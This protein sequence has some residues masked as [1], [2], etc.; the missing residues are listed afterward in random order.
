MNIL[1]FNKIT[2][3]IYEGGI[4]IDCRPQGKWLVEVKRPDGTIRK[5]FGDLWFSNLFTNSFANGYLSNLAGYM[6]LGYMFYFNNANFS[7]QFNIQVGSS[8]TPASNSDTQLGNL[9]KST[10]TKFT[11]G[12]SITQSPTSGNIVYTGKYEFTTE[13]GSVTYNEAGYRLTSRGLFEVFGLP[14][15]STIL[16]NRVVFPGAVN[17]V[18]G[19]QLILS[20]A[21][22]VPTLAVTGRTITIAAQNGMN[23]SGELR[24]IGTTTAMAGGT[25]TAAGVHTTNV[26]YPLIFNGSQA[27]AAGLTTATSFPGFNTN[28]SGLGTNS[29]N[30]TWTA[31]T[32]N[33]RNR[34]VSFTWGSGT[35]STDTNF[36]SITFRSTSGNTTNGYQLLL[37]NQMTKAS[38]AT[39]A[40]SLRF[41]V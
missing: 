16:I 35:P 38:A 39:L 25:V 33:S 30:G 36:R 1:S 37:D 28:G 24:C 27:P 6:T 5:P 21:I 11:S 17:L 10:T 29:V 19:E 15:P 8:S 18:A 9:L 20:T 22:T 26:D 34:N 4:D 23:I 32:T 40:L 7:A 41:T 13:T 31:Y 14:D 3:P 12:H 2:K